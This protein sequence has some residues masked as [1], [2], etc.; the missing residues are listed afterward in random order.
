MQRSFFVICNLYCFP[1]ASLGSISRT[2]PAPAD[3]PPETHRG[4]QR[5]TQSHMSEVGRLYLKQKFLKQP[6]G[7]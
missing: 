7:H 6:A 5:T 2:P 4:Q 3:I 1:H